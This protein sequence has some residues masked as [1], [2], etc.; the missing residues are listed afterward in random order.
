MISQLRSSPR[1]WSRLQRGE[2]VNTLTSPD[3]LPPRLAKLANISAFRKSSLQLLKG[4]L[5]E[6]WTYTISI[7]SNCSIRTKEMWLFVSRLPKGREWEILTETELPA[8]LPKLLT[9]WK[10]NPALNLTGARSGW[11]GESGVRWESHQ[12]WVR[13]PSCPGQRRAPTL[14]TYFQLSLNCFH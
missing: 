2:R 10:F 7:C 6:I 3:S 5:T 4:S 8:V 13:E 1:L 9:R 11:G 12:H 14:L